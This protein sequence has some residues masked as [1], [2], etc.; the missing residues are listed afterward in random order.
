LADKVPNLDPSSPELRSAV[1]P[2]N[3]PAQ[4]ASD[5]IE[6]A[7]REAS[8][9]AFHLASIVN[10]VLLAAGGLVSLGLRDRGAARKPDAG[11]AP[12]A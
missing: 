3:P 10:A 11:P 2:L 12:P 5:E 9:D 6:R 8:T 7:A 4:T 1:Q